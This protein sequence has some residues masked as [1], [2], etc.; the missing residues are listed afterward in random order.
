MQIVEVLDERLRDK[1][2][3]ALLEKY[4]K[5]QKYAYL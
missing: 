3:L 1:R 5:S 2:L 4:H